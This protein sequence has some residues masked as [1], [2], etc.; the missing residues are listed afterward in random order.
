[1]TMGVLLTTLGIVVA[2]IFDVSLATIRTIYLVQ[3]RRRRAALL[4]SSRC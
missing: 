3:G 4:A 2:R 1:M